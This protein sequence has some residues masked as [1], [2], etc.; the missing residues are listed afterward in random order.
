M[1]ATLGRKLPLEHRQVAT[2]AGPGAHW[3]PQI[4]THARQNHTS[5]S[6]YSTHPH[7]V[8]VTGPQPRTATTDQTAYD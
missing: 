2:L 4:A 7:T 3:R 5:N 8:T 6:S 1:A